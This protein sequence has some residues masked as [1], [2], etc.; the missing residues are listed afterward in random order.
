MSKTM[1]YQIDKCLRRASS[2]RSE[3]FGRFTVFLIGYFQ[4]LP[5]VGETEMYQTNDSPGA[6]AYNACHNAFES[7]PWRSRISISRFWGYSALMWNRNFTSGILEY[8]DNTF[9]S[10]LSRWFWSKMGWCSPFVSRQQ[11]LFWMQ[12]E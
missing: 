4:Q 3:T 9:H 6:L 12:H 1:L 8:F 11:A 2:K 7:L 10:K 5:P